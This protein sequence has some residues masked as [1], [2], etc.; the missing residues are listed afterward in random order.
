MLAKNRIAQF[1]AYAVGALVIW[2]I[3]G[4]GGGGSSTPGGRVSLKIAWPARTSRY[5]PQ[6]AN[7]LSFALYSEN[8]L[9]NPVSLVVNRPAELP[10]IQ[11]VSFD[12][13]LPADTYILKGLAFTGIDGNGDVVASA[14]EET[15]V[16]AVG[17][18]TV[19]LSLDSTLASVELNDMPLVMQQGQVQQL[20]VTVKD[21]DDN[22]VFL[23]NSDLSW[24][25]VFGADVVSVDNDGN[26][27]AL[28]Q[29]DARVRVSEIGA[30]L[31]SDGDI[32]VG[33]ASVKR[34]VV[35][36]HK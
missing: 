16:A 32:T 35:A 9:I 15:V 2:A 19:P 33:G 10:L 1:L 28:T 8:N 20:S 23:N 27:T 6:Y 5:L 31:Y 36:T 29:G 26:V 13:P 30:G 25:M 11:E 24:S 18:T 12:G 34:A 14:I 7:S 21:K 3:V 17:T 22:T 4:C